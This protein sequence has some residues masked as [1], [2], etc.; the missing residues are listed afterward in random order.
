MASLKMAFKMLFLRATPFYSNFGSR[1][2]FS[3]CS[4]KRIFTRGGRREGRVNAPVNVLARVHPLRKLYASSPL[5]TQMHSRSPK[6]GKNEIGNM[7][8]RNVVKHHIFDILKNSHIELGGKS[9]TGVEISK[10]NKIICFDPS[11][12]KVLK[13]EGV[14]GRGELTHLWMSWH[15][16]CFF[17]R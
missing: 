12:K 14:G 17:I 11:R 3:V 2:G 9:P 4:K 5:N 6:K 15:V 8:F 1:S 16:R 7:I 10:K 13:G